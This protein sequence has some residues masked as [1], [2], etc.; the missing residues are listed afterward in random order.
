M[1]VLEE[2][3]SPELNLSRFPS[4]SPVLLSAASLPF[5]SCFPAMEDN[6]NVG[7]RSCLPAWVT[8]TA[9]AWLQGLEDLSNCLYTAPCWS[10][11]VRRLGLLRVG[12]VE[13]LHPDRPPISGPAARQLAYDPEADWLAV[14]WDRAAGAQDVGLAHWGFRGR[15]LMARCRGRGG[16]R[17]MGDKDGRCQAVSDL[18]H[19][20]RPLCHKAVGPLRLLLR[21][22]VLLR[23]WDPTLLGSLAFIG[24]LPGLNGLLDLLCL[25]PADVVY[26]PGA[27]E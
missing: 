4:P 17:V 16:N 7:P 23:L 15:V 5:C 13:L 1:D 26:L 22:G 12:S 6:K 27:L 18:E 3:S 8:V 24:L 10:L 20:E 25:S 14:S 19:S 9:A 21:L 11:S 2:I